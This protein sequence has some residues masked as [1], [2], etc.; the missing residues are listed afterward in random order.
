MHKITGSQVFTWGP[1]IDFVNKKNDPKSKLNSKK[2]DNIQ[3]ITG[4]Q[5]FTCG[6][7]I[8]FIK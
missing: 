4:P 7:N 6:R 8:D 2:R 5:V 1:K 3:G